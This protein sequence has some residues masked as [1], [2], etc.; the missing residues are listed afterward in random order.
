[1]AAFGSAPETEVMAAQLQQKM[2]LEHRMKGGAS[3]F[4][5]IAGLSII[6]TVITLSG[7]HWHFL[8]GLGITE[9]IDYLATKT[10][11]AG[12]LIAIVLDTL[13]AIVFIFFGVFANKRNTWAF[14]VGMTFY[15]L[16]GLIILLAQ[17]WISLLFHGFVLFQIF[18]GLRAGNE[19]KE[20]EASMPPVIVPST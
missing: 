18:G 10:G 5:W 16:D 9:V 20:L 13:A 2:T 3:W 11:N 7:S 14:V 17:S 1:M 4:Y 8:A 6:N 12:M 19:L 15:A